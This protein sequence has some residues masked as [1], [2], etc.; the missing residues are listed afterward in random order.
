MPLLSVEVGLVDVGPTAAGSHEPVL[1][2]NVCVIFRKKSDRIEE[3][4]NFHLWSKFSKMISSKF[5]YNN[6]HGS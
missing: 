5:E 2:R 4:E 3:T 6:I 1:Q